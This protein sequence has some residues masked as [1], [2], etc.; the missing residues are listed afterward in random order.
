MPI[1]LSCNKYPFK[2]GNMTTLSTLRLPTN[3][4]G[5]IPMLWMTRTE[6]TRIKNTGDYFF[7]YF[8]LF[9]VFKSVPN[10]F[11]AFL[12]RCLVNKNTLVATSLGTGDASLNTASLCNHN[13]RSIIFINP[14]FCKIGIS[15]SI[16]TYG[17]EVRLAITTDSEMFINPEFII[18]EFNK[19]VFFSN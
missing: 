15:F 6:T 19:K 16:V 9:I 11:A 4:E 13:V 18:T 5:A 1:N 17:E 8:F 14:T 2:L 10:R 3:T 12:T 7:F